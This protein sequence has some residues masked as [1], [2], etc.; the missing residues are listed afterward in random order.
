VVTKHFSDHCR[1]G[2]FFLLGK[3]AEILANLLREINIEASLQIVHRKLDRIFESFV[4][5]VFVIFQDLEQGSLNAFQ[6]DWIFAWSV[7][8]DHRLVH[9][10]GFLKNVALG[11]AVS[12]D[13]EDNDVA[14]RK[15]LGG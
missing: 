10:E 4:E 9:F 14:A 1:L 11:E 6:E 2:E 12:R 7:Q 15:R 3:P 5:V 13:F 8:S